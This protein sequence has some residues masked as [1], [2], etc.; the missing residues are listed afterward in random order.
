M[1]RH[2]VRQQLLALF[3]SAQ[4]L[5]IPNEDLAEM[6]SFAQEGEPEVAME[7]F[8]NTLSEN[9]VYLPGTLHSKAC[10]LA[11]I[12]HLEDTYVLLIKLQT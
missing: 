10:E 7:Y 1:K 9:D 2:D 8:C 12:L 3:D 4:G 5:G 11:T 6:A